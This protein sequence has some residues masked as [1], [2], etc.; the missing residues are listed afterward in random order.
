MIGIQTALGR[1]VFELTL[2]PILGSLLLLVWFATLIIAFVFWIKQR[3]TNSLTANQLP[4]IKG[5]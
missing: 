4:L 5:K 3:K 1:T 2:L